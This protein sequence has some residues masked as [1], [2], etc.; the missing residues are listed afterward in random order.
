MV[1]LNETFVVNEFSS[2]LNCRCNLNSNSLFCIPSV[3]KRLRN[4]LGV[5]T[6]LQK[7]PDDPVL[8]WQPEGE[9]PMHDGHGTSQKTAH[10]RTETRLIH[11]TMYYRFLLVGWGTTSIGTGGASLFEW[12]F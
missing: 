10:H 6:L 5:G 11:T 4:H 9:E 12:S 3:Q 8:L 1:C 7:V 2:L